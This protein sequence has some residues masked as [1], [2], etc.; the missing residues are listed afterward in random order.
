MVVTDG[1]MKHKGPP[2]IPLICM[3][4][5]VHIPWAY[6]AKYNGGDFLSWLR[7]F[8]GYEARVE[9]WE[10]YQH[11]ILVDNHTCHKY[12]EQTWCYCGG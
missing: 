10:D 2:I 4:S 7:W 6:W 9:D 5:H 12:R 8:L 11:H 1:P 3:H